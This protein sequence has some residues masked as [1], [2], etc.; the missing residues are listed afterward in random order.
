MEL[1]FLYFKWCIWDRYLI[2]LTIL[3]SIS[4]NIK[5]LVEKLRNVGDLTNEVN[6]VDGGM[7]PIKTLKYW[8]YYGLLNL[9]LI[10]VAILGNKE[11]GGCGTGYYNPLGMFSVAANEFVYSKLQSTILPQ[12]G[13]FMATL[14][15]KNVNG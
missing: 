3:R 4:D 15:I 9:I 10:R 6:F 7:D 14:Q 12:G 5:D 13:N 2:K 11:F 8:T 1:E